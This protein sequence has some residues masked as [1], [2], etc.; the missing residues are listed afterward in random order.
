VPPE[1][2][3]VGIDLIPARDPHSHKA[4]AGRWRR[5]YILHQLEVSMGSEEQGNWRPICPRFAPKFNFSCYGVLWHTQPWVWTQCV[6]LDTILSDTDHT[7]THSQA[8]ALVPNLRGLFHLT[9]PNLTSWK[10]QAIAAETP[11]I[12]TKSTWPVDVVQL[13]QEG[14]NSEHGWGNIIAAWRLSHAGFYFGATFLVAWA[15][16]GH[17]GN[18]RHG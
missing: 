15:Y 10:Q 18:S 4:A 12:Q 17:F 3:R 11:S 2:A 9:A 16:P 6:L 8:L 1:L 13:C 5:S 14:P 7:T